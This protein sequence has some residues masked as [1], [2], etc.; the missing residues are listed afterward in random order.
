MLTS[1]KCTHLY[2]HRSPSI[3]PNDSPGT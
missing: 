2:L 1:N 3:L